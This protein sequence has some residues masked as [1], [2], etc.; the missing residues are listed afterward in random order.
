MKICCAKQN[1][2]LRET[3]MNIYA[4]CGNNTAIKKSRLINEIISDV[5][6]PKKSLQ[7]CSLRDINETR[8]N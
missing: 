7:Q 4:L 3:L 5:I 6:L 1:L 8:D 2:A